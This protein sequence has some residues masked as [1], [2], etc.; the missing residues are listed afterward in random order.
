M[1]NLQTKS[2]RVNNPRTLTSQFCLPLSTDRP[3][4]SFIVKGWPF[5]A[6]KERKANSIQDFVPFRASSRWRKQKRNDGIEICRQI[7]E[8]SGLETYPPPRGQPA[9]ELL[10]WSWNSHQAPTFRP[11]A[12]STEE[13]TWKLPWGLGIPL[14]FSLFRSHSLTC[15]ISKSVTALGW[16]VLR[17]NR[18]FIRLTSVLQHNRFTT[19]LKG[20]QNSGGAGG[21]PPDKRTNAMFQIRRR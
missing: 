11:R 19:L 13:P 5:K 15:W 3:V 17:R 8:W 21:G 10:R 7:F 9:S 4:C 20:L 1:K 18:V 6:L 12:I 16:A 2:K 14:S